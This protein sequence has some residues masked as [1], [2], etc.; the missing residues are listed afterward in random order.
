MS[1]GAEPARGVHQFVTG[2]VAGPNIQIAGN[3]QGSIQVAIP[4]ELT[5][6]LYVGTPPRVADCYQV[7]AESDAFDELVG[8]TVLAGMGGVGK[9]QMAVRAARRARDD[10]TDVV[11]WSSAS[12]RD[13]V[14]AAYAETAARLNIVLLDTGPEAA[15][16]A[17]MN[18]LATTDRRWLLVL[19]DLIDPAD[20]RGLWPQTSVTGRLVVT[21]RRRE[22]TLARDDVCVIQ[23][24]VYTSEQASSYVAAKLVNHP[25]L[26]DGVDELVAKL[27]GLPLAL[28]QASAYIIDRNITCAAYVDRFEDEHT[29]LAD[30]FPE[31]SGLPDDYQ[32]TVSATWTLSIEL[33]DQLPPAGLAR[34]VLEIGS[35]LDPHGVPAAVL[36]SP[37]VAELLG[38][39]LDRTVAASAIE[40]AIRALFRLSLVE[41]DE[42]D[43]VIIHG[44]VQ[45][46]T[47]ESI[48]AGRLKPVALAAADA[49]TYTWRDIEVN[50]VLVGQLRA[51]AL[52]LIEHAG[53]LL[54]D[55]ECHEIVFQAGQSLGDAGLV[56]SAQ[57]HY[58]RLL[59]SV[60][61]SLG[62]DHPGVLAIR[63]EEATWLGES[64]DVSGAIE[65]FESLL[66][67][68]DRI[69]TLNPALTLATR[70]NLAHWRGRAGDLSGAITELEH[71][72]VEQKRVLGADDH[73]SLITRS[74][75][76]SLR[77]ETGNLRQAIVE[78]EAVLV[79]RLRILG[80]DD[81]DT[82]VSR[83]NLASLRGKAGDLGQVIAELEALLADRIRIL[84]PTH[85]DTL[86][87]RNNLAAWRGYA[88]D[89][90][91]AIGEFERLLHSL[92]ATLG[93]EH[94]HTLTS[95]ANLSYWR[96][97]AGDSTGAIAE[98]EQVL[99]IRTRVQG[100]R[101][102][103]TLGTRSD[104]AHVRWT[105][106]DRQGALRE[107]EG[108]LADRIQVL[109]CDNP[110]TLDTRNSIAGFHGELGISS[111]AAEYEDLLVDLKRTLGPDH[112]HTL[113]ARNNLAGYRANIGD[114]HGAL[115]EFEDLAA[116]H[117]RVL[118]PDHPKTLA[119]R[120]SLA[121]TRS[122]TGE[123][124]Q[125][126]RELESLVAD[127][128]RVLGARHPDTRS[129]RG[130]LR[131]LWLSAGG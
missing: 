38:R 119:I 66:S 22:S 19:D 31:N 26:L 102:P 25:Q 89:V 16:A 126:I 69:G 130:L 81:P 111:A 29:R 82:L 45:R 101:H 37:P 11:I 3:V 109:G 121:G 57:A 98:L 14:M 120:A 56:R 77:G 47:R 75:L 124:E 24:D 87:T 5:W 49:L 9:T 40:D 85:P 42:D 117:V 54:W 106:G 73:T 103:D 131:R 44:L 8:T 2:S 71:L 108:V 17:L 95:R 15:A 27:G 128:T 94:P 10:G 110:D 83:G 51:N 60:A 91:G 53:A 1:G 36:T 63:N 62:Q 43:A 20:L 84:G 127:R 34:S 107:L 92:I 4:H 125:A 97:E 76:A 12:S 61:A 122:E 113:A 99:A 104:L 58:E 50:S 65:K 70:S 96:G 35:F 30:L 55:G 46:A 105:E 112:P 68:E 48:A 32:A 28:A 59:P 6:P 116:T 93:V 100:P 21:T 74:N 52:A 64:G 80:P 114:L 123:V 88:G 90:N 79:D 115:R 7:R 41:Q 118:G 23:L 39:E 13:A 86:A 78:V 33:A 129:T 72:L 18:W 67:D